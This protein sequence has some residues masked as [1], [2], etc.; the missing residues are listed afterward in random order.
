MRSFHSSDPALAGPEP[1][2]QEECLADTCYECQ[3]PTG[4]SDI[5]CEQCGIGVHILCLDPPVN[6]PVDWFCPGCLFEQKQ[7]SDEQRQSSDE[8]KQSSDEQKQSS[9]EQKQ[10]SDEQKQSSDEERPIV[11]A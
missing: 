3:R 7:S 4:E 11:V 8:R 5:I 10:S 6:P 2:Q 1:R 9:D